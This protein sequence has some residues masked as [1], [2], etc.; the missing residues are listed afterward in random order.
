MK[1]YLGIDVG[2][3]S[4]K[5]GLVQENGNISNQG[6]YKVPQTIELF[7][8]SI[9]ELANRFPEIEG[10]GLSM[11]CAVD[12]E[13]GRTSGSS[14]IDYILNSEIRATLQPRIN[15]PIELDNDANCA[16]LA[17]VWIGNASDVNDSC[18]VV[19]GS[20]IG[21]AVI[22]DKKIHRGKHFLGGEF[23]DSIHYFDYE[24]KTFKNWSEFGATSSVIRFVASKLNV[25]P[26][27]LNGQIIFDSQDSNPIYKEAVDRFYYNLAI[28]IYN[29]QYS[30]DPERIIV[31]GGI[32]ERPEMVEELNIRIDVI[33]DTLEITYDRPEI[34]T[35]KYHNDANIIG[36]VYHLMTRL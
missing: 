4:I 15:K 13:N 5:Y 23:G 19:C 18:F 2:G 24:T 17:E 33:M 30:F 27:S 9:V 21:G 7:Y 3:S 31:G 11:P 35:C 8:D 10:I 20:G 6:K 28:G 22:K 16:A 36:A 26:T 34:Y 12:V 14:A 25:D 29:I 1:T 32:S